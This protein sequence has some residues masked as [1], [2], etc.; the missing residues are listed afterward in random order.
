MEDCWNILIID[1]DEVDRM[2]IQHLLDG[3]G[4]K[5]VVHEAS[6]CSAGMEKLTSQSFDCVLIDYRLPDATGLEV[7]EQIVAVDDIVPMIL[8][9]GM[10]GINLM[11]SN[12]FN[13]CLVLGGGRYCPYNSISFL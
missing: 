5:A 3:E 13:V 2:N 4:V 9:T 12:G 6:T 1:D 10:G 11:A 8:L 7:M